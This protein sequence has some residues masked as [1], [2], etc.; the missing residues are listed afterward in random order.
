[1]VVAGKMLGVGGCLVLTI[2]ALLTITLST[3]DKGMGDGSASTRGAAARISASIGRA[4]RASGTRLPG[5]CGPAGMRVH[6]GRSRGGIVVRSS[7]VRC[8]YLLS[9]VGN[10]ILGV[11]L[12]TSKASGFT[13]CAGGGVNSTIQFIVGKGA[14]SGPCVGIRVASNG[15]GFANSCAGRRCT[16]VFDRVGDGWGGF[17]SSSLYQ[18]VFFT[19]LACSYTYLRDVCYAGSFKEGLGCTY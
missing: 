15:V 2:M 7:R 3:Y 13:S 16:T 14:I 5:V 9:S 18:K 17:R 19:L 11:G 8:I 10:V 6:S 1:M 4:T 12:A